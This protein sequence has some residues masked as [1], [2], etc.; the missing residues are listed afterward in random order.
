MVIITTVPYLFGHKKVWFCDYL[1]SR[2]RSKI[3]DYR[4]A[5]PYPKEKY[6]QIRTLHKSSLISI[7]VRQL[8]IT[9]RQLRIESKCTLPKHANL[10][11]SVPE[12]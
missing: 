8:I 7:S 3:Q 6:F 12:S 10:G 11:K 9:D 4:S 2:I 1:V 5:D